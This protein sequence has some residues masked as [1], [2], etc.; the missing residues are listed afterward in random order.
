LSTGH[1]IPW[2]RTG[3]TSLTLKGTLREWIKF[4]V[5]RVRIKSKRKGKRDMELEFL[6]FSGFGPFGD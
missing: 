5:D 6:G 1:E 3:N 2:G 4:V